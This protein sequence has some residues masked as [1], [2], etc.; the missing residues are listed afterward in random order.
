M[1]ETRV[2]AS[3]F[4]TA[5]KN[6]ALKI[7]QMLENSNTEVQI[8]EALNLSDFVKVITTNGIFEISNPALPQNFKPT[9]GISKI[10]PPI[11]NNNTKT[12]QYNVVMVK[13]ILVSSFKDLEGI[14]GKVMSDYQNYLEKQWMKELRKKY[15]VKV[16][17]KALK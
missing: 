6:T 11:S 9:K 15:T 3:I 7:K 13:D 4:S 12:E 2:D 1:W 14:R 10:Y 5:E 16:N 8:K 17:K